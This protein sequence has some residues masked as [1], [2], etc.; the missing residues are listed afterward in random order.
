MKTLKV[1]VLA[2]GLCALPAL[3]GDCLSGT[4]CVNACPLAKQAN[5]R[6]ATGNESL[7]VSVTMREQLVKT[8][9]RNVEGI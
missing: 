6:M 8:V 2:L 1:I 4:E 9:L 7:S 3:A 5:T